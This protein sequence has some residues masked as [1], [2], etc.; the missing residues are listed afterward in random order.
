MTQ[1]NSLLPVRSTSLSLIFLL[2]LLLPCIVRAQRLP[3]SVVPSHYA[4]ALTP[5]LKAATFEGSETIDVNLKDPT[6]VITLNAIEITFHSVSI[7]AA[8]A[9][10]AATVSL[11]AQKQQATLT[12]PN[13]IPA[14]QASIAITYSGLLNNELRGFYLS[15][16]AR[17]NYAVTQFEATD[18][19]RAFPSFDEPAM[20]ATFDISLVIDSGD[21]GISNSPIVKD[22][23]G[24]SDGKHT[25][26]FLTTPKMSTYLVAFLVGDFQCTSGE[27]DGVTIR[28]CATPDK[29]AL[30][31]FSVDFAKFALHYYNSYFGIPYP[32]KKLDLIA[33]PDFEA[34]AMENFGAITYRERALLLDE[35]TASIDAKKIVAVDIAHEMA[36]QW[37]GDLVTMQW[38]NNVWLNEGFATWMENKCTAVAHPEWNMDQS[39]IYDLDVTLNIDSQPTTRPIRARADTPDQ[40]DQMFDGIAYGKAGAVLLSVEN[41]IGEESFRRGVHNYLSA[42]LY[43]NATAEDFWSAEAAASH[44]PVDRI[45]ESL[46]AQ[47]GVPLVTF[48]SPSHGTV[49][50]SQRR[51]YLSP[52]VHPDPAQKWTVPVCFKARSSQHCEVLTPDTKSLRIP[53]GTVFFADAGGKGYYRSDYQPADYKALVAQVESAL[54][55]E[56]RIIL[57]GDE[58][59]QA[60]ANQAPIGDYLDL[61]AAVK[62]D[63][64]S[65]VLSAALDGVKVIMGRVAAT[66]QETSGI[67]AWIRSTFGPEYKKLGPPSPSDS[68]NTSELRA[69]LFELLGLYGKDP[70]VID[71]ARTLAQR[72]FADPDSVEPNLRQSALTV[73]ARYGDAA[74]YDQFLKIYETSTNP[75]FQTGALRRL[76][77]FQDPQLLQ[78]AFEF[79]VSN[80]VRNQDAVTQ[81]ETALRIQSSRDQAWQFIQNHWNDVKAQFTIEAGQYLVAATGNLCSAADHD[82]VKQFFA[83]HP[84]EATDGALRHALETINGCTELRSLQE[85]N[86]QSWLA[87]QPH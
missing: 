9:T 46:I 2:T 16:T 57:I 56:E 23:Q 79:A 42:H 74:L 66:P 81:F 34:G 5:D 38:W 83:T 64:S 43:G 17:R 31:P 35:K 77:Q 6:R 4:L 13:L 11:D 78:R 68:A 32:L 20:K 7:T 71:E 51:F 53:D 75:E 24:P 26:T 44:K 67:A 22:T 55:P 76:A 47:P 30:T 48:G 70:A 69:Q 36:H 40:I 65:K 27:Q 1:S 18:A 49:E 60:R 63:K 80:K 54:T 58:W 19:R 21:T 52:S 59:A 33:I 84:V 61:V 86:L 73:A 82:Q 87:S 25:V 39:V 3:D 15:K 85:P 45:M 37:F 12:V 41:Y 29:V 28:S 14:G 50:V 62:A 10:Q 8:G 72:Y